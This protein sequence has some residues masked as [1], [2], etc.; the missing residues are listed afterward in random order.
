M[1]INA[2]EPGLLLSCSGATGGPCSGKP[3]SRH[4]GFFTT[5]IH[6]VHTGYFTAHGANT[7]V[8]ADEPVCCW[9]AQVAVTQSGSVWTW[10]MTSGTAGVVASN[11]GGFPTLTFKQGDEVTFT[12]QA[13]RSHWFAVAKGAS[14]GGE[15]DGDAL[16]DQGSASSGADFE[17][18]L[19]F[20][21]AGEYVYVRCRGGG[22]I[23]VDGGM[24]TAGGG[25]VGE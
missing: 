5:P 15:A 4:P 1:S 23:W 21:E 9:H 10:A 17:A 2:V 11:G 8:D 12:G 20:E 18:T 13:G 3:C 16:F 7:I 24:R 14:H 6:L 22:R 19:T 25:Q